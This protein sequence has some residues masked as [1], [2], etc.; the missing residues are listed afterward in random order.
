MSEE[1][2][3]GPRVTIGAFALTPVARSTLA[4]SAIRGGGFAFVALAP[5]EVLVEG[6]D[7]ARV[8]RIEPI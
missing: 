4:L 5:V 1:I 8:L 7:G 3:T 6:P 2:L